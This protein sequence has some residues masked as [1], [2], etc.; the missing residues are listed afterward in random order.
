MLSWN[1]CMY[2]AIKCNVTSP[3]MLSMWLTADGLDLV[4]VA[5]VDL[6][7]ESKAELL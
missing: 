5:F 2:D 3:Q 7:I 6:R 1:G 4:Q